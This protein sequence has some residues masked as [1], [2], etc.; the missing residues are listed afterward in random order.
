MSSDFRYLANT[1]PIADVVIPNHIM[2]G[3]ICAFNTSILHQI[4]LEK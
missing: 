4:E 2:F 1:W 3:V